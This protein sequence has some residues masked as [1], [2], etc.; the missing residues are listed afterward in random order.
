MTSMYE[1]KRSNTLT[2]E[3]RAAERRRISKQK[4]TEEQAASQARFEANQREL[5]E[6]RNQGKPGAATA[7][8]A[9]SNPSEEVSSTESAST[10]QEAASENSLHPESAETLTTS[11]ESE[12]LEAEGGEAGE[13]VSTAEIQVDGQPQAEPSADVSNAEG[14]SV[15]ITEGAEEESFEDT[16]PDGGADI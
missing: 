9:D 6:V 4:A 5:E 2:P 15:S 12:T 1:E 3:E 14:E 10:A 13:S 11:S 16:D 8:E 7:Q